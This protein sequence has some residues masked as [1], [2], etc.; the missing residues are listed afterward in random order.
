[1]LKAGNN[2]QTKCIKNN[3]ERDFK[4]QQ[5]SQT[6]TELIDNFSKL[7]GKVAWHY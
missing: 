5:Q 7:L 3:Q 1:M 4:R 6:V 2:Q